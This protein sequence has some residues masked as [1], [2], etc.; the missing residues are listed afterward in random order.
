VGVV[1]RLKAEGF[2]FNNFNNYN[3]ATAL[4][5]TKKKELFG[6]KENSSSDE[7]HKKILN[8]V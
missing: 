6:T 2:T 8:K 5:E 4:T 1:L 3:Y 7:K